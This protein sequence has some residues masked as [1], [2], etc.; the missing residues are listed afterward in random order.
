MLCFTLNCGVIQI[1]TFTARK[2]WLHLKLNKINSI[3]NLILVFAGQGLTRRASQIFFE[4]FK[5][6]FEVWGE[7]DNDTSDDGSSDQEV[8]NLYLIAK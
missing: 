3:T 2:Y 4:K 5:R 1:Y 7:S 6:A 8:A